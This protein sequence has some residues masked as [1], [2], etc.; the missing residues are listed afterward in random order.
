M[1][2]GSKVR[3]L[4]KQRRLKQHW[5]CHVLHHQPLG[6]DIIPGSATWADVPNIAGRYEGI[7]QHNTRETP[8]EGQEMGAGETVQ[9]CM[10]Q[11]Q[12]ALIIHTLRGRP[13]GVLRALNMTWGQ[14]KG[15]LGKGRAGW[16][17]GRLRGGT[18]LQHFG[19]ILSVTLGVTSVC[20]D[21]HQWSKKPHCSSWDITW[22]KGA[23][24]LQSP[25]TLC[26]IH[27]WLFLGPSYYACIMLV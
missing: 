15:G 27:C 4:S 20:S 16:G 17:V 23:Y 25:P 26:W 9:L 1:L 13:E 5:F 19:Q 10:L 2:D 14:N 7:P 3:F 6:S 24:A 21:L 8:G 11:I 18:S 22:G 12:W